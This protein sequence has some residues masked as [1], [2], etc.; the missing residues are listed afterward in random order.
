M[1]PTKRWVAASTAV[2]LLALSACGGGGD[3]GSDA[4]TEEGTA[5]TA[6]PD[7]AA[8][9]DE[10]GDAVSIAGYAFE[11]GVLEID[12]E[13]T[14]T[15]TNE[16]TADHTATSEEGAPSAFDTEEL[17]EGDTAEVLFDEPGDYEY[18]CAIHDYM[19]GTIRVMG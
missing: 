6:A 3:G 14:V 8:T 17:G 18:Y 4:T 7:E 12:L 11:P 16:D 19:K 10:S 9:G 15:F 1:T 13:T 2:V 5:T